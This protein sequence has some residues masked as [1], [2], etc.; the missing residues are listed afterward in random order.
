ML[1]T[2][3]AYQRRKL[4][5][6]TISSLPFSERLYYAILRHV[7]K[8]LPD[9]PEAYDLR[10][11]TAKSVT[12]AYGCHGAVPIEQATF[13]EFGAG[14]ALAHPLALRMQGV[15]QVYALDLHRNA[16]LDLVNHAIAY[17]RCG[18]PVSNLDD[19][20]WSKYRIRYIAPADMRATDMAG[21]TLDCIT[22]V[23][24]MEHIPTSDIPLILTECHRLLKPGGVMLH[25]IDYTDHYAQGTDA[26]LLHF[27]TIPEE[28][29]KRHNSDI[30][31]MNRLRPSEMRRLFADADF[32]IVDE[33]VK[34]Q[35]T[36]PAILSNL[37]PQFREMSHPDLFTEHEILV[38]KIQA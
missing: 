35:P 2:T 16:R 13:L 22:S 3:S 6:R 24:T 29:W 9:K 21:A 37:A 12:N 17:M 20:L 14:F 31:Y 5:C 30:L 33:E 15:Q 1:Q 36:D 19:D 7:T 28:E 4:A 8:S 32:S 25:M 27:L 18:A 34:M 11:A 10:V 38:A 26:S 23:T